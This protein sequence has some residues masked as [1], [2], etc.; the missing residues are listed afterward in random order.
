[1]LLA[2]PQATLKRMRPA[3]PGTAFR[4][5][6][7]ELKELMAEDKKL[8]D[9][10]EKYANFSPVRTVASGFMGRGGARR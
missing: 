5:R 7:D 2:L 8:R 3:L 6:R 10:L 1:V 9:V 4:I